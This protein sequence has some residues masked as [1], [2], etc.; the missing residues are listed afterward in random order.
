MTASQQSEIAREAELCRAA[1]ANSKVGDT[2]MHCHHGEWL[3]ILT[4]P[5][6]SRIQFILECKPEKERAER[7][8]RFRP[9][10]SGTE[11][12]ADLEKA[13]A[14]W[15]KARAD[16][17]MAGRSP[18]VLALHAKICGCPWGEKTDIFGKSC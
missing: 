8:R 12:P 17:W 16:W 18:K 15:W 13:D 14:D 6:E 2:V 3:E 4:E 1:F 7:L 11:L 9:L 10:P 5:A